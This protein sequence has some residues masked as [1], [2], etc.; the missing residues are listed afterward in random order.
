MANEVRL[1]E[2]GE[3]I[4][5]G[6]VIAVL[7]AVGD[8]I[9]RDQPV[10]ELETD[11]A[12]VEVPSSAAGVVA[13]VDVEPNQEAQV[14]QVILTV[15]DGD[16][17][18]AAPAVAVDTATVEKEEAAS[19]PPAPPDAGTGSESP[20]ADPEAPAAEDPLAEIR[21]TIA[22]YDQR[23]KQFEATMHTAPTTRG[24]AIMVSCWAPVKKMAPSSMV[25]T[26]VTA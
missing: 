17:A 18:E 24:N 12:V 23:Q 21:K 10:L 8:R 20:P 13:S 5:A 7:V 3:G 11:K 1:P 26:T 22:N 14:G 19:S 15:A 25:A 6:T 16:G 4:D 2:V 9:E